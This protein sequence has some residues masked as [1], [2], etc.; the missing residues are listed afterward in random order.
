MFEALFIDRDTIARYRR[1]PLLEERLSYLKH[2]ARE[3]ARPLTL[4]TVAAAQIALIHLLDLREGE[5]VS[6]LRIEAAADRRSSRPAQPTARRNFVSRAVR[7][8]RFA[9][10]LDE[11]C[12]VRP[13][14]AQVAEVAVFREWMR[15]EPSRRSTIAAIRSTTS[16]T[17]SASGTLPWMRS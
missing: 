7:W 15:N 10:L 16:S 12:R 6:L 8:L 5:R 17:G 13:R 2:C 11:P 3:G 9:G 1:A 4:R 14:H